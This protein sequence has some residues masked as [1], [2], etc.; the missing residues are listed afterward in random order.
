MLPNNPFDLRRRNRAMNPMG[1][2]PR[3]GG[4]LRQSQNPAQF[5]NPPPE[6]DPHEVEPDDDE[7]DD[8]LGGMT[9]AYTGASTR[10]LDGLEQ[11]VQKRGGLMYDAANMQ[12]YIDAMAKLDAEPRQKMEA[13][14]QHL[15]N[16]PTR[17]QY[18]PG[19]LGKFGAALTGFGTGYLEGPSRGIVAAQSQLERPYRQAQ[20]EWG[21]KI[22]PMQHAAELESQD[23]NRRSQALNRGMQAGIDF[24]R[25]GI[26]S[27]NARSLSNS[28]GAATELSRARLAEL[29]KIKPVGAPFSDDKGNLVQKMSDGNVQQLK[30]PNGTPITSLEWA[31]FSDARKQQLITNAHNAAMLDV[32]KRRAATGEANLDLRGQELDKDKG[33]VHLNSANR[34]SQGREVAAQELVSEE[35]FAKYFEMLP[36]NKWSLQVDPGKIEGFDPNIYK[37]LGKEIERRAKIYSLGGTDPNDPGIGDINLPGPNGNTRVPRR[38]NR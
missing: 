20:E 3:Q 14:S 27:E 23:L 33:A 1:S 12:K 13:F 24:T 6:E 34:I 10:D 18:Q 25:L 7:D 30:Y 31:R 8:P 4:V 29:K 35:M 21:N 9:S 38:R 28:R 22:T 32:A 17:E 37:Y 15:E 26:A 36:N 2:D 5:Y 11:T 19:K 16:M